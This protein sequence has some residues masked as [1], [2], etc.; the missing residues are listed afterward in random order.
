MRVI[1]LGVGTQNWRFCAGV[2]EV[3][4]AK[5]SSIQGNLAG[6]EDLAGRPKKNSCRKLSKAD[7]NNIKKH[8]KSCIFS[9]LVQ[10]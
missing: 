4:T 3:S 2:G 8:H 9:K 10:I 5:W 7:S 6:T 1:Y